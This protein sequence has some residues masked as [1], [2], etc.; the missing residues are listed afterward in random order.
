MPL[1]F[2]S[3]VT[4]VVLLLPLLLLLLLF[5]KPAISSRIFLRICW[6]LSSVLM[7][8]SDDDDDERRSGKS[9][10]ETERNPDETEISDGGKTNSMASPKVLMT[11]S[12]RARTSV[13]VRRCEMKGGSSVARA[14]GGGGGGSGAPPAC[15]SPCASSSA[16]PTAA[17]GAVVVVA[18][19]GVGG[20]AAL[21]T[22][23]ARLAAGWDDAASWR[24]A[25]KKR[26]RSARSGPSLSVSAR[27]RV[28]PRRSS[29]S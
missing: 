28:S 9:G 11:A 3:Y 7:C 15:G 23:D 17:R 10:A 26:S 5:S 25:G 8:P 27:L 2:S 6:P 13:R 4:V 14:G 24:P 21:L 12:R 1:I 29:T 18:V 16:V 20:I 19:A 22:S